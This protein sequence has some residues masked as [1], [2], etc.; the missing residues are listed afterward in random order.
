MTL[1]SAKIREIIKEKGISAHALERR[2]GLKHSAVQNI[3]Y[4]RSKNPSISTLSA[5][6]QTLGCTV[7][8]LINSSINTPNTSLGPTPSEL[9]EAFCEKWDHELYLASLEVV[10]SV[11]RKSAK[12]INR[13]AVIVLV[14]EVY[15]YSLINKEKKADCYFA[16]WLLERHGHV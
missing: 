9:D 2:A 12:S 7:S 4:G 5:I 14:D 8:A 16:Q 3:L 1:L 6:A 11:I 10:I 13:E 15:S